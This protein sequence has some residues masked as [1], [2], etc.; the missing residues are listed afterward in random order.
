MPSRRDI[1]TNGGIYHVFNKT[2]DK[3]KIFENEFIAERFLSQVYYY[4]SIKANLRYSKFISL[5]DFEKAIKIKEL[6]YQKYFKVDVLCYSL[7]PNHFHLFL[8]QKKKD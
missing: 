2:I 6:E 4:R 3:R 7:M 5:P 8:K 1:F